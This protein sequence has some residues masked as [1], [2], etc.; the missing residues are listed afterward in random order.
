MKKSLIFIC[1]FLIPVW[2]FNSGCQ[3]KL[4]LFAGG[5]AGADEKGL[6]VFEFNQKNGSL[7]LLSEW[8]VG[9][10][11]SYLCLSEQYKMLYAVYEV[12][13]FQGKASGGLAALQYDPES[14]NLEMKNE[15]TIPYGG[16]CYVSVSADGGF[17]FLANYGSGSIAVV[18]LNDDGIPETVCDTIL[19]VTE[20]P[21]VSH[22]HMI[23]QDPAGKHVFVTDLGLDRIM[24]YDFDT[25]TGKLNQGG[26]NPVHLPQGSGPRH[27]AFNTDGSRLYVINE[28]G[29]TM[30]VLKP[31]EKNNFE[32]IQTLPTVSKG[33]EGNNA[34][35]DIH[36]GKN[37]NYLYGS[38]RGDNTIVIFKIEKDGTLSLAGHV[39]CGGNWPRNFAIDPSGKF[40]LVGNQR[41]DNASVFKINEDMGIPEGPVNTV[42][43]KAPACLKFLE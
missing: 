6:S 29:S 13:R 36:I 21:L 24:I 7:K 11:P 30:M 1:L 15:L 20:T 8:T 14:G 33:Y 41:S 18:K 26:N 9:P 22:P 10:N 5:Y 25:N 27:F 3:E 19:Y 40:L 34:C 31:G 42:K 38:N 16:P 2:L 28:L 35:A 39:S 32:I 17:L 37:G 12:K 23:E 43:I 4:K